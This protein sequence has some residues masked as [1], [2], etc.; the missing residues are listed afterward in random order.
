MSAANNRPQH[1]APP[2]RSQQT[3]LVATLTLVVVI[4]III[5]ALYLIQTSTSTITA[6][7]LVEMGDYREQL[8]RDNERLR[9]EIAELESLPRVMTRAA[10][11][12]FRSAGEEEIQYIIVD[13]YRYD[14]PKVTPTPTPTPVE[15][16][17][18][19]D[20][21]LSGWLRKQW[22]SFREQFKEWREE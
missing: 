14:R 16:E 3:Q 9:A 4:G 10:E 2:W 18:V 8:D 15:P 5:A 1:T 17:P 6:R 20:E 11:L 7:E 21:T 13:G 19:Y 12:G 22:D